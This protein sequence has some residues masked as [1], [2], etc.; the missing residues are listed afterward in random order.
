[1]TPVPRATRMVVKP[2]RAQQ[3]PDAR[4]TIANTSKAPKRNTLCRTK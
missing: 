2:T 4:Q 3:V 1:M